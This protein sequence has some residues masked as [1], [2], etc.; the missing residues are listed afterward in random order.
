MERH[1]S[2]GESAPN[3]HFQARTPT[4]TGI[5]PFTGHIVQPLSVDYDRI[6]LIS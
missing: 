1:V 4:I 5:L 6:Y 2:L 3:E